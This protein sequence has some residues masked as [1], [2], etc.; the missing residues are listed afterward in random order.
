M[1]GTGCAGSTDFYRNPNGIQIPQPRVGGPRRT[2]D[3]RLPWET[4]PTNSSTLKELPPP[5]AARF[6]CEPRENKAGL[7]FAYLASFAVCHPPPQLLQS[8]FH[9]CPRTRRSPTASVNAGLNDS[10]A[11]RLGRGF[12]LKNSNVNDAPLHR[13][14]GGFGPARHFQFAHHVLQMPGGRGR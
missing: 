14:A 13:H 11:L 6:N 8:C 5:C 3:E 1:G 4:V 12:K 10:T 2:G 7:P 9:S